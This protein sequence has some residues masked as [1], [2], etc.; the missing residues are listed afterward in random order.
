[1]SKWVPQDARS[2][3][4]SSHRAFSHSEAGDGGNGLRSRSAPQMMALPRG[5]GV[6]VSRKLNSGEHPYRRERRPAHSAS[7]TNQVFTRM[8]VVYTYRAK[9]GIERPI[10]SRAVVSGD[11]AVDSCD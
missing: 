11:A 7:R 9:A 8:I 4:A 10:V 3:V 5:S 2:E 6:R 1:V